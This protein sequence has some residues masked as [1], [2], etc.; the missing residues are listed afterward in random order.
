MI[1]SISA[2][3][4][5][6]T[7]GAVQKEGNN[8]NTA[9]NSLSSEQEGNANSQG[10][11]T[12]SNV[13]NISVNNNGEVLNQKVGGASSNLKL[14]S[15]SNGNLVKASSNS[16]YYN[17]VGYEDLD[18][19][20]GAAKK[21]GGGTI[22]INDGIYDASSDS[23]D[24]KIEI[25]FAS[26]LTIQPY[27]WGKVTFNGKDDYWFF[28]INNGA[29][30][31]IN[32]INFENGQGFDGGAIEVQGGELT[33]NN[34]NFNSNYAESQ[35]GS[36]GLGGAI[37]MDNGGS[38]TANNCRF[39]NNKADRYGGAICIEYDGCTVTLN[40]CYFNNNT[41]G[42]D[43]NDFETYDCDSSTVTWN[44]NNCLFEGDGS[45]DIDVDA[46]EKSVTIDPSVSD[47]VNYAVLYK[48]GGEYD[49]KL[50][51]NNNPATFTDLDAGTYTVYMMKEWEKRYN[52]GDKSFTI[53]EPNFVLT[54][55]QEVNVFE[56]LSA[57][58]NAIPN[59]GSGEISVVAKTYTES[60][61]FNVQITN[62]IV[63]IGP[64]LSSSESV[65]FSSTSQNY[66]FSVGSNSKLTMEDIII[67]G[68]FSDAA[69][70]FNTNLECNISDCEFNNI[71]NS[72]NQPG[73]PISAQN[74]K[75]V[76]D[77]C[78]FNSNGQT[79]F[80]N[81]NVIIDD[82][83]FTSNSGSQGGA[84][85]A[86]PSSNV[87]VTSS[88]FSANVATDKGGAIYASNL[89]VHG[90]EFTDNIADKG[91]AIYITSLSNNLI[92]ITSCVFD[93]N[94]A[95]NYRNIYSESL[96]RKIN[97]QYNEYDLNLTLIQKDGS[98]NLDY[99][100][101]GG[102]DWGT[103]LNNNFTL[104]SGVK[105]YENLFGEL[106]TIEDN[107]FKINMGVLTGG[108]HEFTMAGM[109]TQG[110]SAD[111]FCG[112]QYYS[113]LYGNEF[114]LELNKEAYAKIVIE[115]AKISLKLVVNNVLIPE[116][117]V[118]NVYA[119]WDDNY[120]IFV[121]NKNYKLEVV[122]GKGSMQLTGLDL[123]NYTVVAMRSGDD[124][125]Y[126]AMNFTSFTISKTYGNFIVLSTNV[127]YATLAEAVA[128]SDNG[129]T[130]YVKNGTYTDTGIVISDKALDIIA[131]NGAVFDAQG[132][133]ANFIIVNEN[134]VV[135]IESITFRGIRN[136]NTNYGAIVNHGYL[137]LNSCNFTDNT[138]TK[139]SFAKNGGAAVFSDGYSLEI[140]NCNFINN[141][142][143][144]KVSTAAVTS[145]GYEDISITNSKFINNS[146]REGGALH[147][148][149]ISQFEAAISSCDFEG[150]TAVKGS[151]IYVG[152]NSRYL[153][154]TLSNFKENDIKNNFGENA[155]LEGGVIYVNANNS[156]V[157]FNLESSTFENNSN[158]KVDGGVI[159][160]DGISKT[161]IKSCI[162]NNNKGNMGSVI[163]IKNHYNKKLILF[164][165]NSNFI[166]NNAATGAI[167]TS[168]KITTFI[169]E[170]L[171]VNN[172]GENRH[173]YSNGFTVVRDSILEVKDATLNAGSVQYGESS[174]IN[175]TANIGTNINV[176]ATVNL[177][178]A[179][180][181][182]ILG[183]ENNTFSYK[184]GI[185]KHGKYYATLNSIADNN[186]NTYLMDS[187]TEI[188][189]V[190]NIPIDFNV[191]VNNITY[192]ETLKVVETLPQNAT[193]TLQYQL[194]G[195]YY[196]KEE[197]ESLILN[198]GNYTL[199]AVYNH[200]DF[201][202]T[203]STVDF[204]V[205]KANPTISVADVEIE[206][207]DN[208]TLNI[209]TNV[210]SIYIIEIEDYKL[211][212]LING[213]KSIEIEKILKPGDYTIKVTSQERVNYLSNYTE[214]NLKVKGNLRGFIN[215]Q[216]SIDNSISNKE[217]S[218]D[219]NIRNSLD[220]N[221]RQESTEGKFIFQ[222][223]EDS[224]YEYCD[225]LS[226]AI[227]K[228]ELWGSG[229]IIIRG[230]TYSGDGFC[231]I[232]VE[233]ELEVTI[234]AY[235]GEEVIF[236]CQ[237][238]DYFLL[239][240]YETEIEWTETTPPVPYEEQT[241][242]PT[243]TLDNI[244][245][246]NG[247]CT[248]G[249]VIDIEA[250]VLTVANCTFRNNNADYGGAIYIGASAAENDA[251]VIGLNT[252]FINNYAND[253]G[254]AIYISGGLSQSVSATF[255]FCTF[256]DNYQGENENRVMNYFA[257]SDAEDIT[258]KSCIFNG[259]GTIYS[260][261]IDK[262]N[263]T[264]TVNGTSPDVFDSV[265]LLYSD[266]TPLYTI[267]NN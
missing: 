242:G 164:I 38:L 188:F 238:S 151:A 132:H 260:L 94:I 93:S 50:C 23:D 250:G 179:G 159:C 223:D 239:L 216:S 78:T 89:E 240:T 153:G 137:T 230:G 149:N 14:L 49:R 34:C 80:I 155:Q 226:E 154:V 166:N 8:T 47:D 148:K 125:F 121:E 227:D 213:S 103:N 99:V 83:T 107:K 249:G 39:T 202:F 265:V 32:G 135:D 109:Y 69:L 247:K 174:I 139:T 210:P 224:D 126:L 136:R 53:I 90:T 193:G 212:T 150:N 87:I 231:G 25:D 142:A 220:N 85:N 72:Q 68:K 58:V 106:L 267:Y 195:K 33:L 130:I 111:H 75:L 262:I 244:T 124:N 184:T 45:I 217:N 175:G 77:S 20:V 207:G 165:D 214:A 79:V 28:L 194:N 104:L 17:G 36:N 221:L 266:E 63:T 117:P 114:Y 236:D 62:K 167:A 4:A 7:N 253:E 145:L 96:K 51:D 182:V 189:R 6:D 82:C 163:F 86:N 84:I 76:L 108:T 138:I 143:P 157:I 26:A 233:G 131:L 192:G 52:Y 218:N 73:N 245:V 9:T 88:K 74:S 180:E 144:L 254:G 97:L 41:K 13:E 257:G 208:I 141:V 112:H 256:L 170:C 92:N 237:N 169:D 15:A 2:I 206:Y 122:N 91:G 16:F 57:A 156:E 11:E 60:A 187:I 119:D 205:Y 178:V 127:E 5:A 258:A 102:F 228:V 30:V 147:F 140:D 66:L 203:S 61:N 259:N 185:L 261:V 1:I 263:Q 54:V 123:G 215:G 24:F 168:P 232:D 65:I 118:L 128:H 46:P 183:I 172:T 235:E 199:V 37:D 42:S 191:S 176:Y 161:N 110:D 35:S 64:K 264:V 129:D 152:N 98:Y 22:Y 113:D 222:Y 173:I 21:G 190:N 219:Q 70:K 101:E 225:S 44:F 10:C 67:T 251:T 248:Y 95:T 146:A 246:I 134:A 133:D 252:T 55:G 186:N 171:F 3:S 162:F 243:V 201:A 18:E 115:R 196:T 71:V 158:S 120:T 19:A 255:L 198:A 197:V 81:T 160:L 177:T 204:E 43:K 59:G 234:K 241:D 56:N 48:N 181:N 209:V 31:T 12:G 29:H 100:L 200:D 229:T 105:D 27:N 40:N 116:T 211:V